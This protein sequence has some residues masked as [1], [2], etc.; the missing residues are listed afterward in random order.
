MQ[1]QDNRE[2]D[3]LD[4]GEY[5][6]FEGGMATAVASK[7]GAWPK[8]YHNDMSRPERP[9][10]KTLQEEIGRTLHGRAVN[11][12]WIKG[13]MRHGFKGA[14]EMAATVDYLF[15]FAATTNA[16]S[17]HHFEAI[18]KAYIDN[19]K[20]REFLESNNPAALREIAYKLNQ[21]ITRELWKPRSNSA[22]FEL[23]ELQKGFK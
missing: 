7:R 3:L 2:H 18:Y 6:A 11:P 20:I 14:V 22:R 13:A 15:A 4:S 10:I 12:K 19:T 16:V 21:A 23:E 9:L 8:V 17:N 5:Y 1:N